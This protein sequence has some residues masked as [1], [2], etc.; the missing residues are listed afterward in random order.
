MTGNH[1]GTE[2]GTF[3]APG[4]KYWDRMIQLSE[5]VSLRVVSFHPKAEPQPYPVVL[6]P[7]LASVMPTFRNILVEL[8][9]DHVVHFVE[10]REKVTSKILGKVDY[11]VESIGMDV[12]EVISHL[13]L[14]HRGYVLFGA[15]LTAT[16]AL[17][18]SRLFRERPVCMVLLEPNAVFDYPPWSLFIIKH[19]PPF[20]RFIKPVVAWY[21]RTFRLNM[22]EDEAM[23]EINRRALDAADPVKLKDAILGISS[24]EIWDHLSGHDIPCLI[25]GASEDTFHRQEDIMRIVSMLEGA[26][27]FDLETHERVHSKEFVDRIREYLTTL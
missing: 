17:H 25:A 3:C 9:E 8:T 7:G 19:S 21:L 26:T 12:I 14:N 1:E 11:G 6:V 16:S 2:L 10:T 13:G 5:A 27:Y 22:Q 15:S 20:Y 23:Y 4:T 24:Y 18:C